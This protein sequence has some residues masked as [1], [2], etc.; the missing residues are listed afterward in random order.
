MNDPE[1]FL[2]KG[3]K[4]TKDSFSGTFAAFPSFA[5]PITLCPAATPQPACAAS[6]PRSLRDTTPKFTSVPPSIMVAAIGTAGSRP[7]VSSGAHA[8]IFARSVVNS[9]GAKKWCAAMPL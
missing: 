2:A 8:P 1:S 3:A 9:I 7:S 5:R 4:E 6:Q